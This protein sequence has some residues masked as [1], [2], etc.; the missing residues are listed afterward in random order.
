MIQSKILS[1][2]LLGG[3][4]GLS[5]VMKEDEEEEDSLIAKSP[6]RPAISCVSD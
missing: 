5:A 4:T 3:Q 1:F 6:F 2:C